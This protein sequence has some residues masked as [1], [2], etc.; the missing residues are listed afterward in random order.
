M[1]EYSSRQTIAAPES[2]MDEANHLACLLGENAADIRTFTVARYQDASGVRYAVC[3]TV[4]KAVFLEPTT[5]GVLPET[6]AHGIDIVDRAKAEAAFASLGQSGGIM[7]VEGD[8][9]QAAIAQMGL[10]PIPV[11]A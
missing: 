10:T 4:V 2:L 5:T 7:M 6:P 3:S 9:P 1:S 8:D 11:E